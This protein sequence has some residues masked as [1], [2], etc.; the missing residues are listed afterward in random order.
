MRFVEFKEILLG[1]HEQQEIQLMLAGKK[2][3]ALLGM[4]PE[5][6]KLVKQGK[7]KAFK[8]TS[9]KGSQYFLTLP[10]EENRAKRLDVAFAK[11]KDAASNDEYHSIN[12]AKIHIEIG[13]LLGYGNQAIKYFIKR[14]YPIFAK[15][16]LHKI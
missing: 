13:K 14:N 9:H 5:I 3:A 6:K 12:T 2:P 10:G 7:L 15:E 16:L 8:S 4:T 11:L 1:P